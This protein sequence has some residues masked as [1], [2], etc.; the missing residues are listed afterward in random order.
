MPMVGHDALKDVAQG[1]AAKPTDAARP[2][3]Q[4]HR[5]APPR[6][7]S[8]PEAPDAHAIIVARALGVLE[9]AGAEGEETLPSG[10]LQAPTLDAV[11]THDP[12][13]QI[14]IADALLDT[15]V[16]ARHPVIQATLR[17]I[18]RRRAADQARK[19]EPDRYYDLSGD[20]GELAQMLLLFARLSR[21]DLIAA[22]CSRPLAILLAY[23]EADGVLPTWVLPNN[24]AAEAVETVASLVY[25]LARWDARR[26][27]GMIVAGARWVADRQQPDGSWCSAAG[28]DPYHGTWL[29]LRLLGA[30]MPNHPAV[31]RGTGFL[32]ESRRP[33]H[34]WGHDGTDPLATALAVLALRA[35]R[36][37]LPHALPSDARAILMPGREGWQG[38]PL[39]RFARTATGLPVLVDHGCST[40]TALF[41]LKASDALEPSRFR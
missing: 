19:S 4:P 31:A 34:G 28:V 15:D 2:T 37:D 11:R 12:F 20:V 6:A 18:A 17:Q 7:P 23:A 16:D 10:N 8:P 5:P 26:F 27:L 38:R 3:H 1:L 22:H 25:A 21:R 40:V 41:A 30:V 35:T 39:L 36:T 13:V 33:G 32:H 29:A 9:R 24:A 14:L